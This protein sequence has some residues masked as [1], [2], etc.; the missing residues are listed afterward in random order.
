MIKWILNIIFLTVVLSVSGQELKVSID[1]EE[2]LIGEPFTLTYT[3][4]SNKQIDSLRYDEKET[5]FPAKNSANRKEEGVNTPY[6]LEVLKSFSDTSY[7]SDHQFIWQGTYQL[8]GWDS[9]YVVIPPE[10]IYIDDSLQFFPAGLV[11]VISPTA[12]PSKPIYDINEAFTELPQDDSKWLKFIES[13]WWWLAL[14][15]L[16]ILVF[17][18]YL[19]KRKR[20][21][22][23]PL[24]LRQ[25]TLMQIDLLEK[26]K[27]YEN[28]LKEY[29]FDLSIVLRRFFAAHYQERIM[30]KTTTEIE[31]ILSKHGLERSMV[32]LTRQLLTQSD[33]VKFAQ[34]KPSLIEV[35]NVTNDARRV[36]NE[37]ADLDLNNE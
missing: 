1:K 27:G 14:I 33:M 4:I 26:S 35:Q 10:L 31:L 2:I 28:N 21:E 37:I 17:I 6:E 20:K 30:D 9:A 11:H 8:T 5:L 36:V 7:K 12:D 25:E 16:G 22:P 13:N 3:V 19:S 32:L 18:F 23:T 24:S 15:T 29:Y 34:S